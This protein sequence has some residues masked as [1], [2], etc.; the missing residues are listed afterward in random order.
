MYSFIWTTSQVVKCWLTIKTI[1]SYRGVDTSFKLMHDWLL[2]RIEKGD[3]VCMCS[4]CLI[5]QLTSFLLSSLVLYVFFAIIS[6][7]CSSKHKWYCNWDWLIVIDR[8]KDPSRQKTFRLINFHHFE[9]T[10][11]GVKLLGYQ[12][13]S[14][15]ISHFLC[16]ILIKHWSSS[17]L[18]CLSL[19]R[20]GHLGE[21]LVILRPK[22]LVSL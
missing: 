20:R 19:T 13:I 17:F 15:I 11:I 14:L 16:N 22:G 5:F 8:D 12:V 2:K 21:V 18:S 3:L 1:C 10:I 9:G 4:W 7:H 6:L